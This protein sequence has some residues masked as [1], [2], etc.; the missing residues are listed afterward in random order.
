MTW[1]VVELGVLTCLAINSIF[2]SNSIVA[3]FVYS[4]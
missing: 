2:A 4:S 3:L 1:E